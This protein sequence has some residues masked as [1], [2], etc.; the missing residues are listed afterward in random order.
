[1]YDGNIFRMLSLVL[2]RLDLVFCN[3]QYVVCS[4]GV[5]AVF[6]ILWWTGVTVT[7]N[8][9]TTVCQYLY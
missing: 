7:V 9:F 3:V 6:Q 4:T 8:T 2:W 1:M 5:L